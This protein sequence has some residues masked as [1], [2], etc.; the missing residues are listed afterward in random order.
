MLSSVETW[1]CAVNDRHKCVYGDAEYGAD[2]R[3]THCDEI[4]HRHT[5]RSAQMRLDV[6]RVDIGVDQSLMPRRM[7]PCCQVH[8]AYRKEMCAIKCNDWLHFEVSADER[9]T[10]GDGCDEHEEE[11]RQPQETLINTFD[12]MKLLMLRH[13][14]RTEHDKTH[15]I[16]E[17]PRPQVDQ[18]VGDVLRGGMIQLRRG[19]LH[20]E[21][22]H[23]NAEDCV[24]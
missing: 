11:H 1:Q 7:M 12:E 9:R 6:E 22:G 18:C 17:K 2:E 20:D 5:E 23:D 3:Q 4:D 10:E 19:N 16:A 13:P 21:D 24:T 15:E 14:E 8:D